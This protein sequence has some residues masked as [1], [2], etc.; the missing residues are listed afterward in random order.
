MLSKTIAP[1]PRLADFFFTPDAVRRQPPG[2][3]RPRSN[4]TTGSSPTFEVFSPVHVLGGGQVNFWAPYVHFQGAVCTFLELLGSNM[5][6]HII[7]LAPT[8]PIKK[9]APT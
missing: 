1:H 4:L 6:C 3:P 9:M 5:I 2:N 7:Y 8:W